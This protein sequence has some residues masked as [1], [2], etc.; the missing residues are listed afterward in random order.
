MAKRSTVTGFA[1]LGL[2]I[3]GVVGADLGV[4]LGSTDWE[5]W[6]PVAA[7]AVLVVVGALLYYLAAKRTIDH[8]RLYTLGLLIVGIGILVV[9]IGTIWEGGAKAWIPRGIGIALLLGGAFFMGFVQALHS[10]R[11]V[12]VRKPRAPRD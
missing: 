5:R 4:E 8:P 10:H 1:G 7:G 3:L 9:I 12:R 11:R 6:G 2:L